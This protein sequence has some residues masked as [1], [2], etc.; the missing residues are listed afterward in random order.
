MTVSALQVA[1][2]YAIQTNYCGKGVKPSTHCD[3]Y[4]AFTPKAGGTR[5]GTLTF[6]DNASS[7][8][9]KVTLTGVGTTVSVSLSPTSLAYPTQ[10]MNT[11]SPAKT[12]TLTNKATTALSI[13]SISTSGDFTIVSRTCGTSLA[14]G[15]S[16]TINVAFKPTGIGTRTGSLSA[17][18]GGGTPSKAT[19]SGIGT[20]VVVAP[21]NLTFSAQTLGTTSLVKAIT[22]TNK[23]TSILTISSITTSGD[24]IIASKTCGT[25]L[26]SGASCTANVAFKPTAIGTRSGSL[27]VSHNGGGSPSKATLSGIGTMVVVAPTSLIFVAQKVGTTSLAKAITVTNKGTSILTLSSIVKTGDFIIISKTCGTSLAAGASC[28]V[29]MAFKPTAVGI[30]TGSLSITHNGGASPAKVSLNGTGI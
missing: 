2:D 11:I 15:T 28:K 19:L 23:G 7:S 20:M 4:V 29:N 14:A 27:S 3:V 8:P 9:Q 1:G 30:R 17:S 10:L 13:T 16:C 25:S 12:L 18:Y 5:A 21:T 26:A 6:T 24:F 22:V